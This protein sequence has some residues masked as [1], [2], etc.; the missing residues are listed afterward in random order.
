[1]EADKRLAMIPDM[2]P[3]THTNVSVLS[4]TPPPRRRLAAEEG[5]K[6]VPRP[7][8]GSLRVALLDMLHLMDQ[9]RSSAHEHVEG[10]SVVRGRLDGDRFV[11]WPTY[12]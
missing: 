2:C 8:P 5:L 4:R 3:L 9:V 7:G 1:M 6:V 10:Y 11:G 12:Q